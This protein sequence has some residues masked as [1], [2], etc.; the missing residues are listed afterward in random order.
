MSGATQTTQLY[1]M[2]SVM[3]GTLLGLALISNY[4]AVKNAKEEDNLQ[5][6]IK[7]LRIFSRV[8]KR[9][10]GKTPKYKWISKN[11][12]NITFSGTVAVR[13]DLL[14]RE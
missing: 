8:K 1:K 14:L 12:Y 4:G 3:A 2:M 10:T 5:D 9:E 11:N 7:A 6:T 13:A